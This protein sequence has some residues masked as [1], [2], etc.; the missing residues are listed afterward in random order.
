MTALLVHRTEPNGSD[1]QLEKELIA[2]C[3]DIANT[4]GEVHPL[5]R[6]MI[7]WLSFRPLFRAFLSHFFTKIGDE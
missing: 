7:F 1:S 5:E 3:L 4:E 2:Q 6:M